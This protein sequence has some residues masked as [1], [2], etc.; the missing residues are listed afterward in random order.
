MSVPATAARARSGAGSTAHIGPYD[1]ARPARERADRS[2]L[3]YLLLPRPGDTVKAW[4]LPGTFVIGAAS[5][6]GVS[7][8]QL[9]RVVAVWFAL[10]LLIYQARYQWNDI[11]G[12]ESD[13]AHPDVFQRGRLPGPI[14]QARPHKLASALVA[15]ARL[16][17]AAAIGL[18]LPSGNGFALVLE[19]G[20]AVFGLG[21]LYERLKDRVAKV[22]AGETTSVV[23]PAIVGLWFVVGGGYAVR[24]MA[25]LA[26]VVDIPQRPLL[27][28]LAT[29][30]VWAYGVAFVTSRWVVE[31]LAFAEVDG[32]EVVW[33]A[34][35]D[36]AREHLLKLARWLPRPAPEVLSGEVSPRAWRALH[37]V[38]ALCAP[39]NVAVLVSAGCAGASGGLLVSA[40]SQVAAALAAACVL[41]TLIVV[42]S[43]P[44]WRMPRFAICGAALIVALRLAGIAGCALVVAPWAALLAAQLFA[45][46]QSLET[47]GIGLRAVVHE[48]L[49]RPGRHDLSP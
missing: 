18:L 43:S 25:G 26:L 47:M 19:L 22:P 35:A 7:S 20:L 40:S 48:R 5:A 42:R 1:G 30:A 3:S 37:T 6:G 24:G 4:L 46:A 21:F 17:L 32:D 9:L 13:Q 16:A 38:T 14:E 11:R 36:Q 28:V 34:R 2:L 27:G 8:A 44:P 10:E 29:A 45:R 33:R 39:W 49:G 23:R 15:G 12:F 31:S 41:S